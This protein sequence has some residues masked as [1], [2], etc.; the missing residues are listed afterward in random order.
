MTVPRSLDDELARVRESVRELGEKTRAASLPESSAS[1][2]VEGN[3]GLRD[4]LR[5]TD[6][7]FQVRATKARLE[8]NGN[9]RT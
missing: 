6:L 9:H 3:E 7:L 1:T 4:F 5:T 8:R 2:H